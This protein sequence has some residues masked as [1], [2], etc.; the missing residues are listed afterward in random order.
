MKSFNRTFS[1]FLRTEE[2]L[3]MFNAHQEE[4]YSRLV[5]AN[6]QSLAF[7]QRWTRERYPAAYNKRDTQTLW[8]EYLRWSE[9]GGGLIKPPKQIPQRA[10][11]R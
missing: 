4:E 8:A 7:L 2:G 11:A 5:A 6:I 1:A 10:A 9:Q 3:R